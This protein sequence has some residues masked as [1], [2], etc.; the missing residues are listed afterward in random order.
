MKDAFILRGKHVLAILLGAFASVIAANAVFITLAV[1]TFPGEEEK[2]SYVQ[3]LAYNARLAER[4][5]QERLQWSVGIARLD[6]AGSQIE[7]E[8]SFLSHDGRPLSGLMVKGA[9]ERP[10]ADDVRKLEFR[11]LAP[12]RYRASAANAGP[13]SWRLDAVATGPDSTIFRLEKKLVAP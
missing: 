2:K 3:G 10:A 11:E 12:G 6:R 8:L 7:I 1:R 5:A 13:G 9:L 4:E